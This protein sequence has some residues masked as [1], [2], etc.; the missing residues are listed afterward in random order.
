[1]KTV[2]SISIAIFWCL[3]F[4]GGRALAIEPIPLES[5]WSG[6]VNIGVSYFSGKSNTLAGVD[7]LSIDFGDPTIDDL[8]EPDTDSFVI[9][10][11]NLNLNY[12]FPTQTQLFTGSSMENIFQFDNVSTLGIRQQFSDRSILELSFIS[13]PFFAPVQVWKDPYVV[14]EPREETDR[15]S[16]GARVEYANILGSGFGVQYTQRNIKIDDE[17]S[18]STQLG[19]TPEEQGLLHREGD[20]RRLVGYYRFQ[21]VGRNIFEVRLSYRDDD[22]DGEAMSGGEYQL[23][24]TDLYF[25]E[26]FVFAPNIFIGT[27]EYDEENPVFDKT[28]KDFTYG[29]GVVLL[30]TKLFKSDSWYGQ[31]SALWVDKDSNI[32]FYDA[33][34]LMLSLGTQY[35]F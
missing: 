11:V 19:L 26:R 22:L 33:G 13:T 8:D 32:N 29:V 4:T 31:A 16:R 23:Q 5:G 35:R 25:G 21:P 28:R 14:G 6:F 7:A 18:G 1:M 12:T 17:L 3:F 9:P 20:I 30:D 27:K 34:S 10:Q 15:T 24:V 2:K